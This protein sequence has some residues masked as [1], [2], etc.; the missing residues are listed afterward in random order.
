MRAVNLL[1]ANAYAPKQRLPHA[2]VV[3]AATAPVLAGALV[4]LGYSLEHSKVS[5]HRIALDVV[6]SQVAALSPSQAQLAQV[7]QIADERTKHQGELADALAKEQPWDVAFDEIGRVLP[8]DAWLTAVTAQS[9]TPVAGNPSTAGTQCNIQGYT[10]S[11]AGVARVLERLSLVPALT[12]VTLGSSAA[13]Q[14]GK[15]NVVQFTI[16]AG[17]RAVPAQ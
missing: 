17:L 9:P 6:Q 10:Y 7:S 12:S 4:Y 11:Q 16:I 8:K 1:P 13:S 2:P 5:D 15:R 3:L 14:I